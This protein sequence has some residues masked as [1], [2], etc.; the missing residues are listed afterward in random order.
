MLRFVIYAWIFYIC[1]IGNT[2]EMYYSKYMYALEFYKIRLEI[3]TALVLER[4]NCQ[5]SET[6]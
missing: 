3:E 2:R 5:N 4:K 6:L 1:M